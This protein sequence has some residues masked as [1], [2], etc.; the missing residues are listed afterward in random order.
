MSSQFEFEKDNELSFFNELKDLNLDGLKVNKQIYHDITFHEIPPEY[1]KSGQSGP[2]LHIV[3]VDKRADVNAFSNLQYTIKQKHN[4]AVAI[5]DL[6]INGRRYNHQCTGVKVCK[7]AN[8][9][10]KNNSHTYVDINNPLYISNELH[11]QKRSL[12]RF[13][14]AIEETKCR[15]VGCSKPRELR[16]LTDQSSRVA[17]VCRAYDQELSSTVTNSS[18][19]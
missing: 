12:L 5:E 4:F 3:K 8:A 7:Y 17:I 2:V 9:D 18:E 11:S 14:L 6:D 19:H 10:F 13:L 15:D 16:A 1:F